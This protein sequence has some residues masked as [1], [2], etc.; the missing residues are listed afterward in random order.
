MNIDDETK[1]TL[2]LIGKTTEE[3]I[4]ILGDKYEEELTGDGLMCYLFKD[5]GLNLI[6]ESYNTAQ[7][8]I[9]VYT[10]TFDESY[11][12]YGCKSGMSFDQV[13]KK[14]GDVETVETFVETPDH[15]AYTLYKGVGHHFQIS[16][17]H[18]LLLPYLT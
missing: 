8:E 1:L 10:I 18:R 11:S 17:A 13:K 15:K 6:F 12:L 5:V 7:T 14:L 9:K 4:S 3:A 16:F 2:S